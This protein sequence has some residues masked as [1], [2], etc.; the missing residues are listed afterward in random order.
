MMKK[1]IILS[2][3]IAL[4]LELFSQ[5]NPST[6]VTATASANVI[7]PIEI[8]KITDLAFGNIASG[9]ADGAVIISTDGTRTATG[10]VSLIDAGSVSNAASFD[11]TG[12]ADASFTI[13][14]PSSVTIQTAGG[15]N[16]MIVNNFISS[17]GSNAVLDANGEAKVFV[18]ATLNVSAQQEA[19]LYSGSFQVIV[20]YN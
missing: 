9:T 1:L 19:G 2:F 8:A 12:F 13:E 18:G 6:T 16:Q 7:Q 11:I 17:L 20:A 10:G 14:V 3:A 4:S 5:G 15:A